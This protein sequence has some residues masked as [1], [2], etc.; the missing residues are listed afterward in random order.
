MRASRQ[1]RIVRATRADVLASDLSEQF[2]CEN[3]PGPLDRCTVAIQGPGLGRWLRT[4][5]AKAL[6]S[7]GGVDT[8]FLRSMLLDLAS[9]PSDADAPRGRHDVQQ[10]A[11]RIAAALHSSDR[12]RGPVPKAS[13]TPVL[14]MSR[15]QQGELNM[16]LLLR[17]SHA[18]AEAF[19]RYEVDRPEVIDAW[20]DD[21]AV[22]THGDHVELATLEQWQRPLWVATA[23]PW[24]T[25][26][27]WRRVRQLIESLERG[28]VPPHVHLPKLLSVFGVS[29]LPPLMV[30]ALQA[31]GRH[32]E[33]TLHWLEPS[34][35]FLAERVSRRHV[36]WQAAERGLD[37]AS[38]REAETFPRGHPLMD[39][40]GRQAVEAQRVLL[41]AEV[42]LGGDDSLTAPLATASLLQ[43]IQAGLH[44]DL[45]PES[46]ALHPLDRS[47]QVHA[48]A[49]PRRMADVV[50][51]VILAALAD[52]SSLKLEDIAVLTPDLATVGRAIQ[53]V[54]A[55]RA[56]VPLALA[57][58]GLSIPSSLQAVIKSCFSAAMA[59][60]PLALIVEVF[61]QPT[62]HAA[63]RVSAEEASAWLLRLENAGARRFTNAKE[64]AAWLERNEST[65]DRLHTL[66]WAV[67][68]LVLGM[69]VDE[70]DAERTIPSPIQG[71]DAEVLPAWSGGSSDLAGLHRIVTGVESLMRFA[72]AIGTKRSI[73]A[74]CEDMDILMDSLLP[75]AA[76]SEYGDER[77]RID[78][79]VASLR[80]AATAGGFT[81]P[82]DGPTA[83]EHILEAIRPV[84]EG[85]HSAAGGITLAR[86]AP[87]RSVPMKVLVIAGLDAGAFPRPVQPG[88]LDLAAAAPRAGDRSPR[89][90]DFQL[91][92]ECVHAAQHRLIVVYQ[93]RD[94]RTGKSRPPSSVVDHLLDACAAHSGLSAMQIRT[95]LVQEHPLRSD[96]PEAW[97]APAQPGF[98]SGA[99]IR[100]QA[101]ERGRLHPQV[102]PLMDTTDISMVVP[103]TMQAWRKSL[104][105]PGEAFNRRIGIRVPNLEDAFVQGGEQIDPN[106]LDLWILRESCTV[107]LLRGGTTEAWMKQ[108]RLEGRLPHGPLGLRIAAGIASEVMAVRTSLS[109]RLQA[110]GW[111]TADWRTEPMDGSVTVH[112]HTYVEAFESVVDVPLLVLWSHG[113]RRDPFSLWFSHLL[114]SVAVPNAPAVLLKRNGSCT[115]LQKFAVQH[116]QARLERLHDI[117]TAGSRSPLP[118]DPAML[119]EWKPDPIDSAE[120]VQNVLH[121]SWNASHSRMSDPEFAL[122][123]RDE[124]W[125]DRGGVVEVDPSRPAVSLAFH[126][127][128]PEIHTAMKEDGW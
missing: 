118:I 102:R 11:F 125:D 119:V 126:S 112:G 115:V 98:E 85:T 14:A 28:H 32:T 62:V 45:P 48:V 58:P 121:G 96:Q 40:M 25:H 88:G 34:H 79:A 30:R 19:D 128:A 22:F 37:E 12:G 120:A 116:A 73:Q 31:I 61:S 114:W 110:N 49:T 36:L 70:P 80:E 103:P 13:I 72:N 97:Q 94:P 107:F 92:L 27:A 5:M 87:M 2:L 1:L 65:D 105:A 6:G 101:A 108:V 54:F 84:V 64:R 83:R 124:T 18:V 44:A 60:L 123:Y 68:R 39:V 52:D 7:W 106:N 23:K 55:E 93:G 17:V 47:L 46:I 82:V 26:L 38:L 75:S 41:D 20:L 78:R 99:M 24:P 127:L 10:L 71:I 77:Q 109:T 95:R 91:F 81:E 69:V 76:H 4:T 74:W 117:A 29:L 111:G 50:H 104:K 21:R 16:G 63:L 89:L 35:S 53:S 90:E 56:I 59:G 3:S 42:D 8:P 122:A 67:D 66:Q 51:E 113:S 43:R 33:V 57:D 9:H 15:N 100:A 86:L